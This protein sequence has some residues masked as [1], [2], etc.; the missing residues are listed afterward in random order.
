MPEVTMKQYADVIGV[1]VERL[2]KQLED[3]GLSN[4]SESDMISDTEK[5]ELLS[6]P[7]HI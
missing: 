3:A 6:Y 1:S 4:K 5:T 2:L 7:W